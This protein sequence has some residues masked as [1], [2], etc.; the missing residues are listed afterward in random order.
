MTGPEHYAEAERLLAVCAGP[1]RGTDLDKSCTAA[2]Q[3]HATLAVAAATALTA[4]DDGGPP[5]E[6][7]HAWLGVA[8]ACGRPQRKREAEQAEAAELAGDAP[9]EVT[10]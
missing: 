1:Q 4:P 6:D 7:W 9:P 10:A 5:R 3:V 2:A 8:S